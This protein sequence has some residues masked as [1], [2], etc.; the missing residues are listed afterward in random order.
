VTYAGFKY[1]LVVALIAGIGMGAV[2]AVDLTIL[3]KFATP[4]HS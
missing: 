2:A 4:P 1:S 3:S